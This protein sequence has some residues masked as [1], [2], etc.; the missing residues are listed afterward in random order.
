MPSPI[1]L[2]LGTRGS[3]LAR[4]QSAQ[5]AAQL[6]ALHPSLHIETVLIKTTG[7]RILDRPLYEAGGKGLFVKELEL[8]ILDKTI[9]F[10]VHS[11]KDVPV[12]M[13]LVEQSSLVMVATPL[14]EDAR[15][16]LV[17]RIAASLQGLPPGARIG[18]G[19]LRRRCQ[20]LSA[21]PDLQIMAV[22]G[23]VDTRVHKLASGEFDGIVLA[24]AGVRRA[25]LWDESCMFILP[26][27]QMV[28]APGQG[29]LALQCRRE[30]AQTRA[31]LASLNDP[32]TEVC[33]AAERRIVA[34]LEGDCHSPIA[35]AAE[36]GDNW[37]GMRAAIG[38]RDGQPPVIW[39]HAQGSATKQG[40]VIAAVEQQLKVK[41][42]FRHLHGIV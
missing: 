26:M 17:S 31:I 39:A 40:D 36:I 28:P 8:A 5:V 35:I 14:R 11:Y 16:V 25:G 34:T 24:L 37:F 29:A 19:S 4:T 30:D 7:D 38:G 23:N 9:D 32:A 18:T 20:L 12:T 1:T 33:V 2:R 21:R 15:D 22:R 10:A 3:L 13:P 41:D 6:Q 42:A 27:Q